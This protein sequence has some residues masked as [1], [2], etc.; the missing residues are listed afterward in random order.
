MSGIPDRVQG[1][2]T[3]WEY[4]QIES[5]SAIVKRAYDSYTLVEI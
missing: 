5:M 2:Y 1:P 4:V 3:L